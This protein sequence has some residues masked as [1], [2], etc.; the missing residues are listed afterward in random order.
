MAG[1]SDMQ[2]SSLFALVTRLFEKLIFNQ[3]YVYLNANKLLYEHQPGFRLLNSV[4]TAP[5]ASTNGWYLNIDKVKYTGLIFIDLKKVF[6]T[7]DN[8]IVLKKLPKKY[9]V[10]S[11]KHDWFISYLDN[12][13]QFCKING[14]SS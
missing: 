5:L 9:G 13:R 6:D 3:F 12:R 8:E 2:C 7:V 4:T 1:G 11:L 14:T 10:T